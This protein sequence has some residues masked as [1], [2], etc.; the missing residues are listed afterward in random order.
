M[1]KPPYGGF[2]E[3]SNLDAVIDIGICE[4]FCSSLKLRVNTVTKVYK[5]TL[6][7]QME[8]ATIKSGKKTTKT[9]L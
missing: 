7:E 5:S 4:D 2:L 8:R 9:T 6:R 1:K 3:L